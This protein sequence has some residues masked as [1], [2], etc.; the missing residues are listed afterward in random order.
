MMRSCRIGG[1]CEVAFLA[2]AIESGDDQPRRPVQVDL[3]DAGEHDVRQ[4]NGAASHQ[5]FRLPDALAERVQ[6]RLELVLLVGLRFVIEGPIARIGR[7]ARRR[8]WAGSWRA[9]HGYADVPVAPKQMLDRVNVLAFCPTVIPEIGTRAGCLSRVETDLV[10]PT[11][12]FLRGN[13]PA[14]VRS[15]FDP[16]LE[17]FGD[18]PPALLAPLYSPLS[19]REKPG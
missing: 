17:A 4:G 10:A 2:G 13:G 19:D 7:P 3:R 6:E 15:L 14:T 16:A 12:R 1:S 11:S 9:V 18:L 5:V 8:L